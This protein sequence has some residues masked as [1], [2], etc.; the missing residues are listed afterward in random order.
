[1]I[2][3]EK[4]RSEIP[5]VRYGL[6]QLSSFADPQAEADRWVTQHLHGIAPQW[7]VFVLGLGGGY[8]ILSLLKHIDRGRLTVLSLTEGLAQTVAATQGKPLSEVEVIEA[9][10]ISDMVKRNE[11]LA[12]LD[13]PYVA[14]RFKPAEAHDRSGYQELSDFLIGRDPYLFT[15]LAQTQRHWRH[16]LRCFALPTEERSHLLS[17]KDLEALARKGRTQSPQ[18]HD[19]G[20]L[21]LLA[22]REMVR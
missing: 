10:C 11:F 7:H 2:S 15:S 16:L 13:Q 4:S 8:H 21:T 22:L 14:L 9:N 19:E 1:M 12:K 18:S 3:W 5:V 6:Y 20:L 17:V